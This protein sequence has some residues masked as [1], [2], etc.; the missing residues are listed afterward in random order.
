[1]RFTWEAGDVLLLD[2]M[3]AAHGRAAFSGQREVL[4]AMG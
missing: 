1:V 4:V 2:N 3:L